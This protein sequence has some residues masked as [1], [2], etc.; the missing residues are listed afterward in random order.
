MQDILAPS[1]FHF[2]GELAETVFKLL[3]WVL[4]RG[5][6]LEIML[7][8]GQPVVGLCDEEVCKSPCL[9]VLLQCE[10]CAGRDSDEPAQ[11]AVLLM[12][13]LSRK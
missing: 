8:E 10:A 3:L 4:I 2:I 1:G 7:D 9:C 6:V 5:D 11:G 12:P 13:Q